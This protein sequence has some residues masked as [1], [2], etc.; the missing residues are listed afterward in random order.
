MPGIFDKKIFNEEV[1]GGYVAR[2]PNTK[3]NALIKSKAIRPRPDLAT[4]MKDGGGGNFISTQLEG[5]ISGSK[6]QNYDGQTDMK[7]SNLE[8]FNHSR[9]VVGRMNSW[10]EKDFTKD[11]TGGKDFMESIAEQVSEYW[12]EI[13][14]DTIL[15]ILRGIFSMKG[16]A[17]VEFVA[18]H[19]A[20]ITKVTNSEGKAGYMDATSLNTAMQR[21]CGD[22][23]A[24]FT[25][26]LMHSVVATDLE[27]L[28]ILTYLKYTDKDGMER[29]IGLAT[30]NG[31]FVLVDDDMPAEIES[32]TG[33]V[34]GKYTIQITTAGVAEDTI[35]IGGEVY[36]IGAETSCSAKTIAVGS[37]A[38]TQAA[39]LKTVLEEQFD[40]IFTV[41]TSGDTVTL[42]QINGGIGELPTV[43]ATGTMTISTK[44]PTP[45]AFPVEKI[46]YTTYVLGDGAFEY[47]DCGATVPY[48]VD[49]DPKTN[50]GQDTL[51]SRQRKCF[52]PF[53]ISYTMKRQATASP[54]DE[55][56]AYGPNWTLVSTVNKDGAEKYISHK[57]IP[58]ARII[59]YG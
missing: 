10:T 54:D 30:L 13:D 1:F 8:T 23:K 33:E 41:T 44:N 3:R 48:E 59:S 38:T 34:N 40:G 55:E 7:S 11:I 4:A 16:A 2:I 49:R 22:N 27:N 56:L 25:M 12:S 46:R 57:S 51:Y 39:A 9:V 21:A 5:L 45:G 26:A 53:G 32:S 15:M 37:S 19:T 29:N 50:G 24:S 20:D 18:K 43:K 14:Q 36:T 47:T 58:I 35:S 31:R 52:A 6:P 42:T 17:N 28:K